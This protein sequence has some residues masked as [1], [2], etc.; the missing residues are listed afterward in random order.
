MK[1]LAVG[2]QHFK[3]DYPYGDLIEDHRRSERA[4][5]LSTI[6]TAATDCDAVVLMGDNFDKRHN[7][8]SVVKDFVEFLDGFG[9]KEVYIISGNHETY[10]GDK[11][12]LDF[13]M[14]VKHNWHIITPS[15]G[16]FYSSHTIGKRLGFVPF[17]TNASLGVN[18]TVE[19]TEKLM[20]EIE[21]HGYDCV[22]L[23]H[24]ISGMSSFESE[25]EIV[26]PK[27]RLEAVSKLVVA[28]HIHQI[29]QVG[30][31]LLTGNIMSHEVGDTE[32]AVWKIDTE[33]GEIEKVLLPVRPIMKVFNPTISELDKIPENAIVK[34]ILTEK[35]QDID[36]LK[37]KLLWFDAHILTEQYPDE[38]E[39]IHIDE[40]QTLDLSIPALL[41]LYAQSKKKDPDRLRK[42]FKI[43]SEA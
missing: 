4:S 21:K 24:Q 1:I 20:Q 23:H 25:N 27:D 5:V 13:L 9:D 33:S 7:H 40:G 37:A 28:G 36:M 8:S 22:F 6:H 15:G 43:V 10:D 38:R 39:R 18:T 11:T 41:D 29:S 35:G 32:K 34:V 14:G 12:A 2:D 42:A 31:T 17:M 19:A 26:L 16:V 3:L 30:N